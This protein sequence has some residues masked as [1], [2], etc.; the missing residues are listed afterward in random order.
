MN[1]TDERSYTCVVCGGPDQGIGRGVHG[2]EFHALGDGVVG[3]DLEHLFTSHQHAV[4]PLLGVI[5]DFDVPHPTLFPL[6]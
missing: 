5:E 4:E 1:V 3:A 2:L 6:V